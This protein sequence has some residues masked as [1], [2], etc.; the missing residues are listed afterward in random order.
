MPNKKYYHPKTAGFIFV[1]IFAILFF[2]Y[3][4]N[5]ILFLRPQSIHQWRQCDCL[6]FTQTYYQDGNHFFE[7]K[8]LYLGEDGTGKTA[9]DFPVIYYLIAK[10]WK[11][12]GKHEFI[13]RAFVLILSFFGLFSLFKMSEDILKDSFLALWISF[14]LFSSPMLVYYAN[15]FLM[16]VPAFSI[17]LVA[18]YYFYLFYKY[19]VN[20]YLYISMLFYSLAGLIKIPALTSFVAIIGLLLFEQLKILKTEKKIFF[21]LKRQ[22]P[23]LL[24][25]IIL[26]SSWYLYAAYYNEQHNRGMFLIGI[27]PIW[28]DDVARFKHIIDNVQILWIDSYQS[29]TIQVIAVI[30]FVF[31]IILKKYSQKHLWLMS[32]FLSFGFIS[33]IILWFDVFDNHDYYLINQLI[34]M[35]SIF[36]TFFFTLKQFNMKIFNSIIFR[37]VLFILLIINVLHC[38]K[39]IKLRY[40]GWPNQYHL[41]VTKPLETITPYLRSIGIQYNDTVLFIQDPSLNISLYLMEQK[42]YTNF[43]SRLKDSSFIRE[44][45]ELGAKYLFVNDTLFLQKPEL[46]P[47][48]E[49][50]IGKYKNITIFKL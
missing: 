6:S 11:I 7:P 48:T 47:F 33:F 5:H 49:Q 9:T 1:I 40:Y 38:K 46:K 36:I 3:G 21:D 30:M 43:A 37:F 34:F 19:S 26:V 24:L 28:M 39:V 42:G 25:V 17:A 8:V 31:I 29:I 50:K 20:K 15:N 18:L 41:N 14:I 32:I 16:N 22:L 10:L 12:F 4:F 23:A 27:L 35:I 13:Y 45:I 2:I 44:K